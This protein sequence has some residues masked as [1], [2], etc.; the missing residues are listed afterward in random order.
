MLTKLIPLLSLAA[1]ALAAPAQACDLRF[2]QET[3]SINLPA[4]G[5][6]KVAPA[7]ERLP[8]TIENIGTTECAFRVGVAREGV[9][10]VVEFPTTQVSTPFGPIFLADLLRTPAASSTG[11]V[12]RH[13]LPAGEELIIVYRFASRA[14]WNN[15]ADDYYEELVLTAY[16]DGT[17]AELD[18]ARALISLA[19]Q[20]ATNIRFVGGVDRL[21]L[22]TLSQDESTRS[23]PFALRVF[24]TAPYKLTISSRNGGVLTHVTGTA[25]IPYRMQLEGSDLDLDGAGDE[26]FYSEPTGNLGQVLPVSVTVGPQRNMPAGKYEDLITVSITTI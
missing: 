21:D 11:N 22:G 18:S 17:G 13:T 12:S 5:P 14:D 3:Y 20:S 6:D 10:N 4:A 19:I 7:L 1:L 8:V 9:E 2:S 16:E 25:Q 24:S 15:K 23:P 26:R